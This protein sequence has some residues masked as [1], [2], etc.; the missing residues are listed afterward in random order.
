M[1]RI[2]FSIYKKDIDK[3]TSVPEYKR[4]Q[5]I[6]Y[7]DQIIANHKSYA[8]ICNADYKLYTEIDSNYDI[9]QFQKINIMK[10]LTEKYDEVLYLDF[11][12]IIKT[13]KSFF[14][15][16]DL[17]KICVYNI[18]THI[19]K[20][21]YGHRMRDDNWHPMDMY[22]KAC[23]KNA[24]LLL[25]DKVSSDL[26]VNTGVIGVNKKSAGL[27]NFSECHSVFSNAKKD[28]IYPYEISKRWKPNNEVYLSYLL[29]RYDLP[30]TNIGL[31]WNF[32]LDHTHK[33]YSPVAHFYH[34]VNKDFNFVLSQ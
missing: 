13:D 14:E 7:K 2:I 3:H 30:Y 4:T 34:C 17:N 9:I 6:K 18:K 5:F 29:E 31:Q 24:M 16:F 21:V 27:I 25:Q 8:K 1:K 10:N 32:I 28:T 12:I 20:D 23:C 15:N 33:K 11:D 19:E 22:V 26:I